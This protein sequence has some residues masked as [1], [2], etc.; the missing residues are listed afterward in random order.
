MLNRIIRLQAVAEIITNETARALS[1][2]ARKSTIMHNAIYQNLL[3]LDYLL[4]S[5]GGVCGKF[6]LR[7][8]CLQIDDEGKITERIT[9][10]MRKL[11]HVPI[12]TWKGWDPNDLFGRWFSALGGFKTL[13][14]AMGLILGTC[15]ILTCLVPHYCSLSG[16][17]WRPS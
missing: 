3:A 2:L 16:L 1:L 4:A 6:N 5:E 13:I 7:N 17:L 10:R 12:Q 15:L 11:A 8:C 9:D 14:G